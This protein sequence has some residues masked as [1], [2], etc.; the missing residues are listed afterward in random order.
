MPCRY[1]FNKKQRKK[2]KKAKPVRYISTCVETEKMF[3]NYT[4]LM[5]QKQVSKIFTYINE[6][7]MGALFDNGE[8]LLLT[9]IKIKLHHH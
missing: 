4:L 2:G 6:I 7:K 9:K 8:Y 3:G 5:V 1:S